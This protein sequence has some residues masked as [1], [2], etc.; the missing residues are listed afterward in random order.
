MTTPAR[1][2]GPLRQGRGFESRVSS[3]NQQSLIRTPPFL[4]PG[5]DTLLPVPHTL[6]LMYDRA[7]TF[8]R[9]AHSLPAYLLYILYILHHK[10][11][12][13]D[14]HLRVLHTQKK[15]K[16][17][18]FIPAPMDSPTS[19]TN[20]HAQQPRH[21]TPSAELASPLPHYKILTRGRSDE[22]RMPVC[23]R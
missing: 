3:G 19:S 4:I 7:C 17:N 5:E 1:G 16:N 6:R 12:T 2:Q 14:H 10:C 18:G 21:V 22:A 20:T 15:K 23:R 13:H 8:P 9:Y 11:L